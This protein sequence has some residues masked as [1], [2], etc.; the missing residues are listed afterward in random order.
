MWA[1]APLSESEQHIQRRAW[2]C[3]S[4][5]RNG[6]RQLC[7]P[8]NFFQLKCHSKCS[9]NDTNIILCSI[10]Y[11][12]SHRCSAFFGSLWGL[13]PPTTTTTTLHP[14]HYHHHHLDMKGGKTSAAPPP[15]G[16]LLWAFEFATKFVIYEQISRVLSDWTALKSWNSLNAQSKQGPPPSSPPPPH[17]LHCQDQLVALGGSQLCWLLLLGRASTVEYSSGKRGQRSL[18]EDMYGIN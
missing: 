1:R 18:K 17:R 11:Q 3:D 8:H 7:I 16:N 10:P 4:N 15:W 5:A 9:M 13:C 6:W 2:R 12:R 14:P